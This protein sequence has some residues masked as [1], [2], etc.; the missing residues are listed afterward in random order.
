MAMQDLELYKMLAARYFKNRKI[1]GS[2]Y[3]G[4]FNLLRE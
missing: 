3:R 4:R 1:P 2:D